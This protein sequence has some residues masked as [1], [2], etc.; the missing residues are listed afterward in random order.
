[1]KKEK[2]ATISADSEYARKADWGVQNDGQQSRA[3]REKHDPILLVRYDL[4]WRD[5]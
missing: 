3:D 1:M 4:V 5:L 2:I